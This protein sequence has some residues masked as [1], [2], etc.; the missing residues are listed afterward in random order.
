M[1]SSIR[2]APHR[3]R[4]AIV[5]VAASALALVLAGCAAAEPPPGH[6]ASDSATPS[7]EPSP[8]ET[9]SVSATPTP[10][11]L[12]AEDRASLVEG[13]RTG[14]PAAIGPFLADPVTYILAS[15]SC[16]GPVT[17][18]G[19]LGELL[20]DTSAS[21]GWVSPIDMAYLDQL[22][23]SQYYADYV[24]ADVVAARADDGLVVVYGITGAEVTSILIGDEVVLLY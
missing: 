8:T 13:L 12:T 9:P 5:A 15:S 10:A 16:C 20:S 21:S 4:F 22:R 17:P 23:A 24:P 19:A 2:T 7:V 14:D 11:A 6:S 1:S 3:R 18:E